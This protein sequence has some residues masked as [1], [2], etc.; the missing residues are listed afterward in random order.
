ML[1]LKFF[2]SIQ[3]IFRDSLHASELRLK[4]IKHK[5]NVNTQTS[6]NTITGNKPPPPVFPKL[7]ATSNNKENVTTSNKNNKCNIELKFKTF[8]EHDCINFY[9]IIVNSNTKVATVSPTK[10]VSIAPPVASNI[11]MVANTRKI[12]KKLEIE[13]I[14]GSHGLGFS[15]TTR[16]NP[17][18]GNCPIY[19]K[20]VLPKVIYKYFVCILIL[21]LNSF[22]FKYF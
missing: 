7:H 16:D 3:E 19:I 4:V 18:G 17:A 12:G 2:Y 15:V 9:N 6:Q 8:Y 1:K 20:N 22:Y 10:K 11:L 5:N 21:K 13:L 14:K